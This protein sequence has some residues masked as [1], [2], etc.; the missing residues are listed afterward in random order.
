MPTVDEYLSRSLVDRLR[1]LAT[2]CEEISAAFAGKDD[3]VI[4]RRPESRS[5]SAREIVCHLRDAEELFLIRFQT[6]L[7]IDD[8]KILTFAATP[9]VLAEWGIAEGVG[10]PLDPARWAE[11]RQYARCDWRLAL[12]AFR[13]RR[14]EVLTLLDALSPDQWQRGGIHL[15]RGR[16]TMG[17][18]VA[19]LAAHDDNHLD[20]MTRALEARP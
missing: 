15:L 13:R 11:E 20:Q 4:G 5:W 18:W 6:I 8:P 17:E 3:E 14:T 1:R 7:A 10:H 16:L 12:A 2:T 19:S 9:D